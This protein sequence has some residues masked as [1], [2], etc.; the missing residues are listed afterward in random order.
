MTIVVL[1]GRTLNPGDNPWTALEA[2]GAV[3]VYERTPP[4]QVLERS[5]DAQVLVINKIRL[6]AGLIGPHCRSCG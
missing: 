4:H 3:R 2:L 1:D 6:D 5:A